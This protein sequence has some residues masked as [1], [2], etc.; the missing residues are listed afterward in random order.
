MSVK[1]INR[2]FV[3]DDSFPDTISKVCIRCRHESTSDIRTCAA[4]PNG[5]PD[6]IWSG[7]NDH[8]KPFPGDH[9][10]QFE[11]L[12]PEVKTNSKVA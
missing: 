10:I 7:K 3:I 2:P 6:E 4:F 5:I 8:R 1:A 11:A 9:G 12:I